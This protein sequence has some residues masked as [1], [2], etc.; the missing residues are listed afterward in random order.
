MARFLLIHGAGHGAWCWRA[1]LPLLRAMGHEAEAL[2][3]P[4]HGS[5]RTIATFKGTERG[6]AGRGMSAVGAAGRP[7]A[8]RPSPA[9]EHTC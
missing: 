7:A 5:D 1:V 6:R 2:D 9:R 4:S 8:I 3:L